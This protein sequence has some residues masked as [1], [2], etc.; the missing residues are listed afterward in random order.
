[1]LDEEFIDELLEDLNKRLLKY[2][3]VMPQ[4]FAESAYGNILLGV[5][6]RDEKEKSWCKSMLRIAFRAL[7]V[8][9]YVFATEAWI[10]QMPKDSE[11][12]KR[13][14]AEHR[15][16]KSLQDYPDRKEGI[17]VFFISPEKRKLR[18][19]EI[20][21][22]VTGEITGTRPFHADL[23]DKIEGAFAELLPGEQPIPK[24]EE[25]RLAKEFV[26]RFRLKKL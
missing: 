12:A 10:K 5:P 20:M 24:L 4:V 1:M 6:F 21:R 23:P 13:V 25:V 3:N 15:A 19:L 26:K 14:M 22:G 16:G 11:D 2:G 8:K 7:R 9:R 18:T 17:C